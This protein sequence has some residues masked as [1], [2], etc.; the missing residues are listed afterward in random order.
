MAPSIRK[1]LGAVKD[2]TSIGLAMMSS[3]VAPEL[4]VAIVK[5]TSH[6][7]EPA[8]EKYL[9][10][11]LNM[12][13]YSGSYVIAC[14]ATVSRRLAKTRDWVVALKALML[15]HRLLTDGEPAFQHEILYANRKGARLL[16]MSHFCDEAHSNSLD[17]S[18]FVRAYALYLDRRLEWMGYERKGGGGNRRSPLPDPYGYG[19]YGSSSYSSS[20]GNGNGE[21][22]GRRNGEDKK[23]RTPLKDMKPESVLGRMHEL[24]NVLDSFLG[25]RPRGYAKH[26]RIILVALY[27]LLSESFQLYADIAEILAVLLDGFFDMDYHDCVKSFE[28][29]ARAAKLIDELCVF[30]AWCKDTGV[31]RSSEYPEVERI[32]DRLLE[33]LE[34]FTR[35][36]ATRTKSPPRE[37]VPAAPTETRDEEP[38][39]TMNSI[40]ALPAPP[41]S[42]EE[43]PEPAKVAAEP[44]EQQQQPPP[45][46]QQGDLVDLR[47]D[48]ASAVDNLEL[49]L[50]QAP[51][52]ANG[53]NGSWEAFPSSDGET[54]VTSAWQNPAAE[55]G[56]ADWEMVLV[57]TASNLS[58]QKATLGGGFHPLLLNGMYDQ[59]AVTQH[60]NAQAS[61]GSASSMALPGPGRGGATSVLALPAPD[62]TVKTIGQ[63]PFAASLGIPPPPFVQ[64][65]DA[66]KKRQL[67][68]QEQV[69]WQQYAR[70]GMQGQAGFNKPN[71]NFMPNPA[72]PY[73]M[74]S[75][76]NGTA[77]GYYYPTH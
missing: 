39:E 74:P 59:G 55:R 18:A 64:M 72:M 4:D 35:N 33:L 47:D 77:G 50:F 49:A 32:T 45:H 60:V 27:P 5:A 62:G 42:E 19:N 25:C 14:V 11:I 22:R 46:Q 28:A 12:T 29:Y 70:D 15:V 30:Y 73:G 48:S 44:V 71:S 21:Y 2:Q 26:S 34:E 65:A 63:D 68:L 76:Y 9:R 24:L 69:L 31:A 56:K 13:S 67:L 36:R 17:H 57:E 41:D 40:K 20:P 51:V 75:A 6:D 7:D 43:A 52:A 58:K 8:D 54:G 23:P 53:S 66:E 3:N 38:E 10:E 37:A 16:C 1:A 61:G